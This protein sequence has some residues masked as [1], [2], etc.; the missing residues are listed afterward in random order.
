MVYER[1]AAEKVDVTVL[2]TELVFRNGR[3]ANNRFLKAAL[4]EKLATWDGKDDSKRGIPT[5]ELIN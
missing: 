2:G 5:Q 3:K 4:S 1:I